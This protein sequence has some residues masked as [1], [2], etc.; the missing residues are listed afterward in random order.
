MSPYRPSSRQIRST[1]PPIIHGAFHLALVPSPPDNLTWLLAF[2]SVR[3]GIANQPSD[4]SSQT[5]SSAGIRDSSINTFCSPSTDLLSFVRR[6]FLVYMLQGRET[7]GRRDMSCGAGAKRQWPALRGGGKM[8]II[9][10]LPDP[11]AICPPI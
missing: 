10:A 11:R 3:A 6:G 8:M 4:T 1:Y 5:S 9:D 7:G 2:D